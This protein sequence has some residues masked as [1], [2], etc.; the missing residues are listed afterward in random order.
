ASMEVLRADNALLVLPA[1]SG[2][3]V[4]AVAGGFVAL[5]VSDGTFAALRESHSSHG[6]V[7]GSVEFYAWLFCWYVVQYFIIIFFNTALVGAAI[8]LLGGE[9]PSLGMAL[10][11]AASRIGPI[12]GYAII[13][14][15]V[16]VLLRAVAERLGLIGRLIEG[17]VGLAW[18]AAT[19]LVVPI[20]AAE[21]V[22]PWQAIERS[23]VLLRK[24]WGENLIGNAGISLVMSMITGA[25]TLVGFGG[26]MLLFQ[27]GYAVLA[28]ALA[29]AAITALLLA[30]LIAS[31]LSGIYA[32]AVYYFSVVGKAPVD[33]DGDLIRDAFTRKG[34]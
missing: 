25:I 4:I 10:K 34:A 20:L 6:S 1:I 28:V 8:A 2:V 31:A 30:I 16:G 19:F 7:H 24:T 3:A 14:A 18:T 5:A 33:F 9:R 22:G 12:L 32:A 11:L 27:R 23:T 13:S 15:T 26:A 21:D 17:A 29:A